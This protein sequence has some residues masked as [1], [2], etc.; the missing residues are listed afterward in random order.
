VGEL[1]GDLALEGLG[2][3]EAAGVD[4]VVLDDEKLGFEEMRG[5]VVAERRQ[6][7]EGWM[8]KATEQEQRR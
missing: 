5:A 3:G 4:E 7:R 1:R 2:S 6:W 8:G